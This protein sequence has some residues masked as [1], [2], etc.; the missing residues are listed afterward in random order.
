MVCS[1]RDNLLVLLSLVLARIDFRFAPSRGHADDG[2]FGRSTPQPR[3]PSMRLVQ[4][5]TAALTFLSGMLCA[6]HAG[7]AVFPMTALC[8]IALPSAWF[9]LADE[10]RRSGEYA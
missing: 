10:R 2:D 6:S 5:V 4:V 1:R 8:V 7:D 3:K 9:G